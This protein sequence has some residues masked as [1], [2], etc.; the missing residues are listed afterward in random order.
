MLIN[1][2]VYCWRFVFY[3][4]SASKDIDNPKLMEQKLWLDAE[5]EKILDQRKQMEL[6]EKVKIK[7]GNNGFFFHQVSL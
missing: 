1:C 6:L 3:S 7:T 5:M 2:I 4:S